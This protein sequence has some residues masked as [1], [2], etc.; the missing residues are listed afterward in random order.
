MVFTAGKLKE[1]TKSAALY[2]FRIRPGGNS[3]DERMLRQLGMSG[4]IFDIPIGEALALSDDT[5]VRFTGTV[6]KYR[7][8]MLHRVLGGSREE[9]FYEVELLGEK[10]LLHAG[11]F[12]T[13]PLP[14]CK[15]AI[16]G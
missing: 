14:I 1:G 8:G 5:L 6:Y 11:S 3:T 9:L 2:Y 13:P 4:D 16:R 15:E 10:A 12:R 7:P